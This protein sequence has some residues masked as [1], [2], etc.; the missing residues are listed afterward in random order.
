MIRRRRSGGSKV[1]P[2]AVKKAD[3]NDR[4]PVYLRDRAAKFAETNAVASII[5]V[6]HT[7]PQDENEEDQTSVYFSSFLLRLP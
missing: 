7:S 1:F 2:S 3:F 4:I 6:V 5:P